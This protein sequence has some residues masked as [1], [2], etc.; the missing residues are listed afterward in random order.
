MTWG[1]DWRRSRKDNSAKNLAQLIR[2][3]LD[4]I[5]SGGI[6]KRMPLKRLRKQALADDKYLDRLISSVFS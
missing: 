2:L 6:P 4:I 5:K 1:E 3:F